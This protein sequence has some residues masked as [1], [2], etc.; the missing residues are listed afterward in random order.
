M[1][2]KLLILLLLLALAGIGLYHTHKPLPS[3]ISYRGNPMPL[4]EPILLT[5]VTRH[6]QDGREERNHEI[7]DE[8]FRLIRQADEF[9][10]I[11]M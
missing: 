3:G 9:I 11:D 4:E 8:V 6:Y 2:L 10:L 7:F 1:A 5:D